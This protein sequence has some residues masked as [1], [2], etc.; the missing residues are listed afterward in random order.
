MVVE[1]EVTANLYLISIC[2]LWDSCQSQACVTRRQEALQCVKFVFRLQELDGIAP[3]R[4][5]IF[6]V[7]IMSSNIFKNLIVKKLFQILQRENDSEVFYII[8]ETLWRGIM[9]SMTY[10]SWDWNMK[11]VQ[12]TLFKHGINKIF[13][14]NDF[15]NKLFF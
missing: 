15:S 1:R 8:H 6:D 13:E 4:S 3:S 10:Y 11:K 7:F 9:V 2:L 5:C 12:I 14:F